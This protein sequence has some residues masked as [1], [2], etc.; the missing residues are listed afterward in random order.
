MASLKDMDVLLLGAGGSA[1]AVALHVAELLDGGQLLICNRTIEHAAALAVDV[2][3]NGGNAR[4]L[5]ESELSDHA[6]KVGLIVNS[7][8]KGQGGV[9]KLAQ[10]KITLLESYSAL[11]PR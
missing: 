7:T 4:A 5:L 6:I 1:R 10:N 8:T 11:A 3:K 2:N 9:R